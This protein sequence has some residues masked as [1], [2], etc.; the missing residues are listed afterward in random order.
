[1]QTTASRGTVRGRM[2][3]VRIVVLVA[4]LAGCAADVGRVPFVANDVDVVGT[5]L[6]RPGATGRSCRTTV[7]G[8]RVGHDAGTIDE[9]MGRLLALDGEGNVVSDVAVREERVVTG[10]VN[11]RCISVRG[12]LGRTV[13]TLVVPMPGDHHGHDH[14]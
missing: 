6:L 4:A 5:K 1:M 8:M 11:R 10:L 9:A 3:D 2:R 14:R 7:L 13:S 12:D